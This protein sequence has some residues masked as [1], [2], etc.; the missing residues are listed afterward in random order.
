LP[1]V[2][3]SSVSIALLMP[4]A[5]VITQQVRPGHP[6]I[7]ISCVEGTPV[8]AAH[9]GK[10]STRW[11]RDLGWTFTLNAPDGL[12]TIYAHLQRGG[13]AGTYSRGDVIGLCGNTGRL[14]TGA[15][16]HFG[17]NRPERLAVLAAP[18]PLAPAEPGFA[19]PLVVL[20]PKP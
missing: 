19:V 1:V 11:S 15:H 13:D 4:L 7:D 8:R 16:L 17:S 12:Q 10:G 5:G 3:L 6:A 9:D 20:A 18:I 2:S 14:T